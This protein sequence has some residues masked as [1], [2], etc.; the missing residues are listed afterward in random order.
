[1]LSRCFLDFVVGLNQIPSFFAATTTKFSWR[2]KRAL[3]HQSYWCVVLPE[4]F[5]RQI[6]RFRTSAIDLIHFERVSTSMSS[7]LAH[8]L[9]HS[10]HASMIMSKL[11]WHE[12]NTVFW[13]LAQIKLPTILRSP[14]TIWPFWGVQKRW[15]R[16]VARW[17][18]CKELKVEL[19]QT[20]FVNDD[21]G[22]NKLCLTI[23]NVRRL[24]VLK[25]RKNSFLDGHLIQ[26]VY[27]I[28]SVN[29]FI[30][31]FDIQ[32]LAVHYF[33]RFTNPDSFE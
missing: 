2:R 21:F 29:A 32:Y 30:C 12:Y 26:T 33:C 27:N 25:V 5:S 13:S 17:G 22:S 19:L 23:V 18:P 20:C 7:F 9:V 14:V 3:K 10:L 8:R 31:E 28:Q 11:C 4:C 6:L 16:A 24:L 15:I 1:M